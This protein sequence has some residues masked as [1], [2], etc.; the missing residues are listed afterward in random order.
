[1]P[2][3]TRWKAAA[4][5]GLGYPFTRV[6]IQMQRLFLFCCS[7]LCISASAFAQNGPTVIV[8]VRHAEKAAQPANNPPLTEAGAARAN[9]L[10]AALADANIQAIIATPTFRTQSTA[11]PLAEARGLTIETVAPG[12]KEVHVKAVA[13]AALAHRGQAVLVV[14]HSNTIPAIILALGGPVLADLCDTQYAML[15][16]V[17]I[18]GKHVR[19]IR[20]TYGTPTPDAPESCPAMIK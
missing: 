12:P 5:V 9:A 8:L 4:M 11:K 16:T 3:L 14:G 17:V 13:A 10:A 6:T 1:M 15:Y 20:S 19:L 2:L 7:A 18:D